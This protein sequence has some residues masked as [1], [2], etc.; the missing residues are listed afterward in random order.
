MMTQ[1]RTLPRKA[2]VVGG[3]G[4]TGVLIVEA[5]LER[6]YEV[7]ILHRGVHPAPVPEEVRRIYADPHWREPLDEA[8]EGH[9]FDLTIATYGRLRYVAEALVGRTERLISV[10]GALPVYA[11]WMNITSKN[12]WDEL[13][14]TPFALEENHPLSRADG[15][16][17]FGKQVRDSEDTVLRLHREGRFVATH[18]RYPI[19]YGP[20]H[21]GAP[22]WGIQ[23]RIRD[24]RKR[25]IVPGGGLTLLSRGFCRN[26]VHALML[27]LDNPEVSG[28]EL[29]NICDEQLT[30]TRE[31]IHKICEIC[32]WEFETVDIPF[33]FLP[34]G[35]RA[36]PT[37]LLYRYHR[38]TSI[39]KVK[40]QLGYR[41]VYSF[42]QG[43]R[44]TV[45]WY[46]ENPLPPGGEIETN[47][48]DPYDYEYEDQVIDHYRA[49]QAQFE[50]EVAELE[51][52]P[53][54]WRHPYPH[55][56]KRGDL[57]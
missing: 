2:L 18:F 53:V 20:R 52:P 11:G 17:A 19:V 16:D 12:P 15:V 5:L 56:K 23:R 38:V 13:R 48:G 35:F 29:Y 36:A 7:T 46:E 21:I 57:R 22:E 34:R 55:P 26:I 3:A 24:R 33:D 49:H 44:E 4:T 28:G 40:A 51:T 41:D 27:A 42:D 45:Q 47:V 6:G 54:V 32:D 10:G 50:E 8:L 39:E 25:I 9:F 14:Q 43:M 31:W 30:S 1:S 37:A